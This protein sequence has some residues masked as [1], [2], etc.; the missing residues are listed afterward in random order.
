MTGSADKRDERSNIAR[1]NQ[2]EGEGVRGIEQNK[3]RGG[4]KR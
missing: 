2:K 1:M 4:Q 3:G